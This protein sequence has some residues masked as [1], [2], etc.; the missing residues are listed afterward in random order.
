MSARK[1]H[2][3]VQNGAKKDTWPPN[4]KPADLNSFQLAVSRGNAARV[5]NYL[6]ANNYR[7]E[8]FVIDL[9]RRLI[10]RGLRNTHRAI[11]PLRE[12]HPRWGLE[13]K[14]QLTHRPKPSLKNKYEECLRLLNDT[15]PA[16]I[17]QIA[18]MLDP[19]GLY[20][21]VFKRH[22]RGNPTSS[23]R[24]DI[25]DADIELKGIAALAN[26]AGPKLARHKSL[27]KASDKAARQKWWRLNKKN[28]ARKKKAEES[29][30]FVI[31]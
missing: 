12:M 26:S 9:L 30:S 25:K 24:E 15:S 6:T 3:S 17:Q 31:G 21:F 8:P 7:V 19:D 4:F 10:L 18:N 2:R 11:I 23:V 14:Y 16:A 5:A 28:A 20:Y 1:N 22:R 13:I 29:G 27:P